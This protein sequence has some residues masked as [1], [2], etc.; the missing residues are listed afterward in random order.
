V[1]CGPGEGH[2]ASANGGPLLNI[3]IDESTYP[4]V[5]LGWSAAISDEE[6]REVLAAIDRLLARGRPFGL[7]IDSRSGLPFSGEQRA[8]IIEH[9]KANR[10]TSE[11]L[12]VQALVIDN[13]MVR[14][15]YYAVSWAVPMPFPSKVFSE[16]AAAREWLELQLS[17]KTRQNKERAGP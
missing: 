15:L 17:A 7:L 12:L 2:P 1:R 10:A 4:I 9:I 3:E 13:P 5:R 11:R 6:T 14:A 8:L 16:V